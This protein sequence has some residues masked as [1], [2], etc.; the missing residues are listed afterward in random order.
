MHSMGAPG[1][2][3]PGLREADVQGPALRH[4]LGQRA[5]GVLDR[6][7]RVNP[8]LV[9]EVDAVCAQP[10][11]GALDRGTD[12]GLAAVEHAGT[13]AGK[14]VASGLGGARR[15]RPSGLAGEERLGVNEADRVLEEVTR[16]EAALAPGPDLDTG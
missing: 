14:A 2:F 11:Q 15:A 5:D 9:V 8:L 12:V 6:G 3:E 16:V 10:L 7:V 1:R 4:Q 13:T